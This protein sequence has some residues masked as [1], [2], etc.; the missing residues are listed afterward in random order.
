MTKNATATPQSITINLGL[1]SE[2]GQD[3]PHRHP[4]KLATST[5]HRAVIWAHIQ[6][7]V[8]VIRVFP[9]LG[10]LRS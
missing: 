10:I 4:T 3:R 2:I 5:A 7:L 8:H 9:E 6:I 1:E